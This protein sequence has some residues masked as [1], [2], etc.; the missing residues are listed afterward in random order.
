MNKEDIIIGMKVTP[1]SKSFSYYGR[2]KVDFLDTSKVWEYAKELP[3]NFLYVTGYDESNDCYTLNTINDGG[4]DFF[5]PKDFEPYVQVN[6][7]IEG[8]NG[9]LLETLKEN[10]TNK[11]WKAINTV[12]KMTNRLNIAI[13]FD[14]EH[15]IDVISGDYSQIIDES[16]FSDK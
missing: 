9:R 1:H 5:K 12:H 3:Q 2:G 16:V 14:W 8:T 7:E 6:I 4:G 13:N 15:S 10:L 11:E